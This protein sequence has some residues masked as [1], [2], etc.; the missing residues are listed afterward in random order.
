MSEF[1]RKM[2][3]FGGGGN[4]GILEGR[5]QNSG[6]KCPNLGERCQNLGG[7]CPSLGE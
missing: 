2:S 3:D 6:K 7:K 5:S 1:R 4:V